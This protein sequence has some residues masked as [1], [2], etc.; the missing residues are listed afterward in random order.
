M[1]QTLTFRYTIDVEFEPVYLGVRGTWGENGSRRE[2]Q[3]R[4]NHRKQFD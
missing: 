3:C 4:S 1:N 2:S